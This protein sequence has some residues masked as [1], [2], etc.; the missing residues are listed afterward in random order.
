MET[1]LRFAG[2]FGGVLLFFGVVGSLIAGSF[3]EMENHIFVA[4]IVIGVVSL[5]VWMVTSGLSSFSQAGRMLSGRSA[6]FGYNVV[7]Y[8]AV[9]VGLLTL[10]NMFVSM[11]DKRWDLTE[12]GVYSLSDKSIKMVQNLRS[13][14]HLVAV[15]A[16]QVAARDK[17]EGLLKLYKYHNDKAVSYKI[18][19]PQANPVEIDR[20]G[21]KPGNLMYLELGEGD[22][23]AVSRIN[24]LDEQSI[25][26]AIVKLSKG[27]A[28]KLYYVQGHGEAD[29]E[30]EQQGG[31]KQFADALT[32]EHLSIEGLLLAQ[33]GTVPDDAAAVILSDPKQPLTQAE[34]DALVQ[35]A[36]K[37]GRLILLA[38][39][40]NRDSDEVRSLAK[41]FGIEVGRDV[42]VDKQLQLFA[43]P[44][45]AVQFIAQS[46]A[47]HP[48]ATGLKKSDP[49]AFI[50]S[51]SVK[52]AQ[53][54]SGKVTYSE[55]I[56][57][58]DS[59]WAE[60]N[61]SM[62]FD[63]DPP[64]ASLDPEDTKGPVSIAV[65]YEKKL[66][67]KVEAAP[68]A[69]AEGAGDSVTRV[70]VFGD[71]SWL[72]NG[73]LMAMGNRALALNVINWVAGEEANIAIGPKSFKES[74]LPMTEATFK[75]ILA[76]SLIGP[77]LILLLGLFIWWRRKVALA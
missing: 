54:N 73:N 26:N 70:V 12:E 67:S 62:I 28:K 58:G 74:R 68:N 16:P 64:S 42:I 31:M 47:P 24:A 4:H 49:P 5:L 7:S 17:T 65:A 22:S 19:S 13:P 61:L 38:N 60:K 14:L 36:E 27:A 63:Q 46:F 6:R 33:R 2:Y 48:I 23:R 3:I 18:V 37:G 10:F 39:G 25:T 43:G 75:R 8:T 40:E 35:Y 29:L 34:R 1:A 71:A 15:D 53:Q 52:A 20:L 44:Q 56:K 9:F 76:F 55:F 11:N 72:E 45:L 66:T 32:D 59:S 30:S 50:F 57:S 41:S 77:E 21:L 51:S 69:S